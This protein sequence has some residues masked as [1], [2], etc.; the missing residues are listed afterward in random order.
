MSWGL[1]RSTEECSQRCIGRWC[2]RR[3]EVWGHACIVGGSGWHGGANH[4]SDFDPI[5]S[6]LLLQLCTSARISKRFDDAACA[7]QQVWTRLLLLLSQFLTVPMSSWASAIWF[8]HQTP[9]GSDTFASIGSRIDQN[10]I[11]L[12]PSMLQVQ[13]Q[14]SWGRFEVDPCACSVWCDEAFT[15][16]K[17][18]QAKSLVVWM[19][20]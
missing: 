9:L 1:I 19:N 10:L 17:G 15:E 5:S 11:N 13:R 3:R 7:V 2:S 12:F 14:A 8:P 16:K 4:D 6:Q 20:C 18:T